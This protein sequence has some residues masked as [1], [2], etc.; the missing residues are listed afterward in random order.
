VY[1]IGS[2]SC[3]H[4][5][6]FL[7][8]FYFLF[9]YLEKNYNFNILFFDNVMQLNLMIIYFIPNHCNLVIKFSVKVNLHLSNTLLIYEC[10]CQKD[11]G[12]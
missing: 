4:H 11:G 10:R 3:L 5:R 9:D 7:V 1:H 6:L 12:H 8:S 2:L